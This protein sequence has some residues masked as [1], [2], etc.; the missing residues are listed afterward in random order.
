[1]S[2]TDNILS[3]EPHTRDS[4]NNSWPQP[5]LVSSVG[6]NLRI[7][8]LSNEPMLLKRNEHFCHVRATYCP[9]GNESESKALPNSTNANM[10]KATHS[11]H[12]RVDPGVLLST[13]MRDQFKSLLI[14]YDDVFNP[15]FKGYNGALGPLEAKMN[16]GPVQPPQRKGRLPQYAKSQ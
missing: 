3:F 2:S 4:D 10:K 7:P 13:G 16:M 6:G 9:V 8:N 1:M 11:D 12:V 15:N 5:F 14:K